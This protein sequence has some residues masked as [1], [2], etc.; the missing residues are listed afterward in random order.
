[1]I[2]FPSPSSVLL[3]AETRA[4]MTVDYLGGDSEKDR[5]IGCR[6]RGLGKGEKPI[7]WILVSYLQER[8][9]EQFYSGP[10]VELCKQ[11]SMFSWERQ[12]LNHLFND[13]K[14][15]LVKVCNGGGS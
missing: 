2:H 4:W 13:P 6:E 12:K 10:S 14:L 11:F 3:C 8:N 15:S 7:K 1:M 9:R 5:I